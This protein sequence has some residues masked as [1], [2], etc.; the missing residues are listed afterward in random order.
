MSAVHLM[1]ADQ[2]T[3]SALEMSKRDDSSKEDALASKKN[4]KALK[5]Y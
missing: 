2:G 5:S 1:H 3:D 4:I